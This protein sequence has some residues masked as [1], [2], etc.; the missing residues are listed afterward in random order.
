M[1]M[2]YG[3]IWIM[4]YGLWIMMM[5]ITA[6]SNQ[7]KVMVRPVRPTIVDVEGN[8]RAS[9]FLLYFLGTLN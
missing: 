4:D 2:D 5:M 8:A 9:Y 1:I 3:I 7:G 6:R